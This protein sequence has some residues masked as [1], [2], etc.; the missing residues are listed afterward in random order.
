LD[1]ALTKASADA[2]AD[3]LDAIGRADEAKALRE[4]YGIS[5]TEESKNT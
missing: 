1:H 3:V 2:T 5:R 4:R